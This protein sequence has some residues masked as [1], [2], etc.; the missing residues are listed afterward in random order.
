M[1]YYI[2]NAFVQI[3]QTG[4]HNLFSIIALAL[5]TLILNTFLF[6]HN[7]LYEELSLRKTVAPLIAYAN[8]SVAEEDAKVFAD[9]IRKND[10]IYYIEYISKD[11][12]LNRAEKQFGALGALIKNGYSGSNPFPASLE[13][14][15]KTSNLSRKT[16]EEIAY[17]IESDEMIDDVVLTGHG[18]LTDIYHQTY[19]MT[20]ASI[21]ITVLI[22]LL[23]IRASVLKTGRTRHKEIQLLNNIGATR[24]YLRTPFIIQGIFLGFFGTLFGLGCFYILYCL[25][26]FQ[27]GVL[28]FLPWYQLIAVVSASIIIGM[29]SGVSAYKRY[30]KTH[31]KMVSI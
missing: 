24:G 26:T 21:V 22:S 29:V 1:R 13:I 3:S 16:L 20:V 31:K 5:F 15:F 11:E 23:L 4:L 28:E 12:H 7:S 27:L 25:F 19:R 10:N 2:Q 17:D 14:Y 9:Q 8:D 30:A 6:N 18:I